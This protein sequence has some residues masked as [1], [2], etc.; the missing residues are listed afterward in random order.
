VVVFGVELGGE[1][2]TVSFLCRGEFEGVAMMMMRSLWV[3]LC[4]VFVIF[5]LVGAEF[6]PVRKNT[7]CLVFLCGG[8]FLPFQIYLEEVMVV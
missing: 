1:M 5:F 2:F 6:A 4:W 3:V 7:N 8:C